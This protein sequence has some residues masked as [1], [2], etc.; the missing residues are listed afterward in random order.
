MKRNFLK[1]NLL[2]F[3][4]V[5]HNNMV[6]YNNEKCNRIGRFRKKNL[7]RIYFRLANVQKYY[8]V[9]RSIGGETPA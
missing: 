2:T 8:F 9:E 6:Q 1:T 4:F 5:K 7:I 3:M